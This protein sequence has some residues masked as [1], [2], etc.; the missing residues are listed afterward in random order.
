MLVGQK[1]RELRQF[2]DIVKTKNR[3]NRGIQMAEE[4]LHKQVLSVRT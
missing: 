3:M 4:L 2:Y 1:I